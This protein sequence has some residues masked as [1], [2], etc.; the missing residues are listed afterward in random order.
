[1]AHLSVLKLLVWGRM[2]LEVGMTRNGVR[3]EQLNLD[4]NVK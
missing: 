3:T 1:M 4:G 2:D